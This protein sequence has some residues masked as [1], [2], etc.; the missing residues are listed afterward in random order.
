MMGPSGSG[1]STLLTIF[2]AMNPPSRGPVLIDDID[3][4]GLKPEQQADFCHEYV[5]FVFQQLQQ[6]NVRRAATGGGKWA[7]FSLAFLA[8]FREGIELALRRADAQRKVVPARATK[9]SPQTH[10]ETATPLRGSQ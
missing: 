8:V 3:V 2:G 6:Q 4:C 1:K 10:E 7:I 5:G 9:R